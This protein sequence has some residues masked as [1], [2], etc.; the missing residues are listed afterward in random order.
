MCSSDYALLQR[1]NVQWICPKCDSINCDSF[2]FHSYELS[3]SNYYNPL[4]EDNTTID[5]IS[6]HPLVFSPLRASSPRD[7]S[8]R[9][10]QTRSYRRNKTTS[11]NTSNPQPP[12]TPPSSDSSHP[13]QHPTPPQIQHATS[14]S[15]GHSHHTPAADKP[16]SDSSNVYGLPKKSN[17]RILTLNC[18]R[19][20]ER[21]L[22][23]QLP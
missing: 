20:L 15:T 6:S 19:I 17:L 1:S 23:S 4:S 9:S 10:P 7:S 16:R 21:Q 13:Q 11:K 12:H 2:T 18:Q 3:C 14:T 22:N 8:P 5:S